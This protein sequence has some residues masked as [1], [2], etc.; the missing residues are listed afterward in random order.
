MRL[1]LKPE[2][3]RPIDRPLATARGQSAVTFATMAGSMANGRVK[4][5]KPPEAP[6]NRTSSA[7][8]ITEASNRER[9]I[10]LPLQHRRT[11]RGGKRQ[12]LAVNLT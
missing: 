2:W 4:D 10:R 11:A 3:A 5:C 1:W 9:S 7:A 6:A 12:V 8:T